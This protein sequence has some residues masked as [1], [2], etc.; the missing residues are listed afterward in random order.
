MVTIILLKYKNCIGGIEMKEHAVDRVGL[1]DIWFVNDQHRENFLFLVERFRKPNDSEYN[2]AS[3]ICAHPEIYY[4][5]T[6]EAQENPIAWYFGEYDEETDRMTESEIMGQLSSS[7]GQLVRAAAEL[8]T[9]SQ[10]YFDL[11]S[12]V[13]NA[14]DDVYRMYI[15]ALEIR[16]NRK[17]ISFDE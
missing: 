1:A 2:A 8:F 4:R 12:F 6:W 10:H 13:G 17:L 9:S 14:G 11:M 7:F 16:R 15:Q 3:Y 5:I